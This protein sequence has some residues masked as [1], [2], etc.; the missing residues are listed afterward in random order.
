MITLNISI[1]LLI[2]T[3][4]IINGGVKLAVETTSTK[5]GACAGAVFVIN[6][7][8]YIAN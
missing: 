4:T 5:S 6:R 7:S 2:I 1:I 8:V 3:I